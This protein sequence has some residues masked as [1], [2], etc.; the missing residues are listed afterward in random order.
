MTH[1]IALI[2]DLE[3]ELPVAG[4]AMTLSRTDYTATEQSSVA[5]L[6]IDVTVQ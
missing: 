2:D 3:L 5:C 6:A 4:T 1:A